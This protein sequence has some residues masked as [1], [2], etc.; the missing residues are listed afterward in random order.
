VKID[1]FKTLLS[2]YTVY[3]FIGYLEQIITEYGK[4]DGK[5]SKDAPAEKPLLGI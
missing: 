2:V 5:K 3:R 4:K 1:Y